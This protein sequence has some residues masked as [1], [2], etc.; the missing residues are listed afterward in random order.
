[1]VVDTTHLVLDQEDLVV[2]VAHHQLEE[3]MQL[4]QDKL[5]QV[6]VNGDMLAVLVELVIGL[7]AEAA[8]QVVVDT[9]HLVTIMADLVVMEEDSLK[10]PQHLVIMVFSVAVAVVAVMVIMVITEL[11]DL[12]AVD[13]VVVMK[14]RAL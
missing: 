1:M 2:E 7:A 12:A 8:A 9:T 6:G 14:A 13:K 10:F 5:T 11:V 4:N 3:V